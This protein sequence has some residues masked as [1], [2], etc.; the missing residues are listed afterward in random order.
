MKIKRV[1]Y[2]EVEKFPSF[3]FKKEF[4]EDFFGSAPAPFIGR[5]GYPQVNI[6]VLSPQFS[7]QTGIFDNPT[8]W[9]AQSFPI[10]KIAG[11]RYQMVNSKQQAKIMVDENY[12]NKLLEV[13]QEVGMASKPVELEVNLQNKPRLKL[14]KETEIIPFGPSGK[15][16]KIKITE[17]SKISHKVDRIVSDTDLKAVSGVLDLYKKGFDENFLTKLISVGNLGLKKNRKLVPTRWSIT[18]IDDTIGKDLIKEIK[19]YSVGDYSVY[20]G[21]DWGNYYLVLF[22]PEVW[23]FELFEM[24][25]SYQVNPWSQKGNFYSTDYENYTGRKEYAK[26]C[27]GGYYAARISTLEKMKAMRRQGSALVLRF[28][29]PEYNMPLGVWVCRK[30]TKKSLAEKPLNFSSQKL[31]LKYATE[32]IKRKFD[33]DLN[34]LLKE[35]KLL[36]EKKVQRKL[37]EF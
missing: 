2:K 34:L 11:M 12:R 24:Y 15:L 21:G 33:F 19:Q 14:E 22:F 32:L 37:N 17:N 29:T 4:K 7:E 18:A 6:G 1:K 36:K 3:N 25:L 10:Q 35:S 8:A 13:C 20:F 30:A 26:E 9:S 16:K 27:A 28:I 5:F 31:M 23:S